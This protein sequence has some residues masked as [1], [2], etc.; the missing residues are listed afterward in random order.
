MTPAPVTLEAPP[1]EKTY[2]FLR[3][4]AG[5]AYTTDLNGISVEALSERPPFVGAVPLKRLRE[6]AT[7]D[8]WVAR[9]EALA[10]EWRRAVEA[11]LGQRQVQQALVDLENTDMMVADALDKLAKKVGSVNSYEG[12]VNATV[13]LMEFR[14]SLR[15]QVMGAVV[16]PS[17]NTV[18]VGVS[19]QMPRPKL[20][21]EEA[22]AAA[23][24]ILKRRRDEIRAEQAREEQA[25]ETEKKATDSGTPEAPALRLLAGEKKA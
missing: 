7:K 22:R 17:I 14:A 21:A 11:K 20:S 2:E 9:R 4:S 23:N 25:K 1:D 19:A 13:R 3:F 15:G 16:A 6:W 12:L 8:Q 5:L 10:N 18:T 24:A